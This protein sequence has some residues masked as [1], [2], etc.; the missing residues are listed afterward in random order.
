MH[1]GGAIGLGPRNGGGIEVSGNT[2]CDGLN[3]GPER[4]GG[5]GGGMLNGGG[6]DTL[7]I[8]GGGSEQCGGGGGG[9][10]AAAICGVSE[11]GNGGGAKAD[12]VTSI[13][14]ACDRSDEVA[15]LVPAYDTAALND[16]AGSE[17]DGVPG[18]VFVAAGC[19]LAQ[20]HSLSLSGATPT[21]DACCCSEVTDMSRV[22]S[23]SL[24]YTVLPSGGRGGSSVL[25]VPL[26]G[27][28]RSASSASSPSTGL[29]GKGLVERLRRLNGLS[30]LLMGLCGCSSSW[31]ARCERGTGD[32]GVRGVAGRSGEADGVRGGVSGGVR[33]PRLLGSGDRPATVAPLPFLEEEVLRE[34]AGGL[35]CLLRAVGEGGPAFTALILMDRLSSCVPLSPARS[36]R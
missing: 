16:D 9:G 24:L 22:P 30:T 20:S 31:R 25:E 19:S 17:S 8:S 33:G 15:R 1:G 32:S 12:E 13:R 34:G 14:G 26:R 36:F 23:P 27:V 35:R 29:P 2:N 28:A 11:G 6:T 7:A 4:G 5:G 3:T 10:G 21:E 18:R